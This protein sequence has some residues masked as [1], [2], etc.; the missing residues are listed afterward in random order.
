ME[1]SLEL[2]GIIKKGMGIRDIDLVD[3][4]PLVLA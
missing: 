3:Y 1:E 4:S 2:F